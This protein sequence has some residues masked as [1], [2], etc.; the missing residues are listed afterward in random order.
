MGDGFVILQSSDV[1]IYYYQDEPGDSSTEL[2]LRWRYC[3]V[4]DNKQHE[5]IWWFVRLFRC[6]PLN[7]GVWINSYVGDNFKYVTC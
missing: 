2:F 4:I 5:Q 1:D 6:C 3:R 7:Y